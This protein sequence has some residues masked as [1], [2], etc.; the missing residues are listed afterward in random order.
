MTGNTFGR[1]SPS[2]R[3]SVC[4]SLCLPVSVCPCYNM[5]VT[6]HAVFVLAMA[7]SILKCI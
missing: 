3:L 5:H 2:V 6:G 7:A 4:V 1:V